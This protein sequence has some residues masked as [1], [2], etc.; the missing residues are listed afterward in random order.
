MSQPVTWDQ[1]IDA[2]AEQ[3]KR[4]GVQGIRAESLTVWINAMI[5]SAGG[6]IVT[7]PDSDGA[8]EVKLG[9][10]SEAG[11]SA[12][13]IMSK[14][15]STGVGGPQLS[16]L[17]ENASMLEFQSDDGGFMVNWPFIY[18]ATRAAV[19][20]G[21]LDQAVLDDIGWTIY[22]RVDESQEAR[23]PLGGINLGVGAFS[24]NPDLAYE[25]VA[26]IRRRRS[27]RSTSSPTAMLLRTSPPSTTLRS[28]RSSPSPTPSPSR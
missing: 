27:R 16:N 28:R 1:I 22:P 21:S 18:P 5:E 26:C 14:I 6:S 13:E 25:A 20:E 24:E 2:A 19:D 17:D 10:D 7:N 8:D 11:R 12:A 4:V 15:G 9:I 23:P 3:D